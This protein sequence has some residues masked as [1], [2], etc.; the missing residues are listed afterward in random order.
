M[1]VLLLNPPHRVPAAGGY[2][3]FFVRAGSRWPYSEFKKTREPSLYRP[4]PFSLAYAAAV[5]QRAGH[6]VR[7]I[8]GVAL[9]YDGERFRGAC[10]VQQPDAVIVEIAPFSLTDDAALARMFKAA[11]PQTVV[12]AVGPFVPLLIRQDAIRNSFDY[13]INGEYEIA[14]AALLDAVMQGNEPAVRG[15]VRPAR[16]LSGGELEYTD[17]I[18]PLDIL[19]PPLREIFPC[20]EQP[21]MAV[22]WDVFCQ[23]RPAIQMHSS[24]GCPYRCYFCVWNQVFYRQRRYRTFGTSRVVDEMEEAVRRFGAREIYFDDDD[25]SIDPKR[26][27]EIAGEI[28]RRGLKVAWGCMADAIN[29]DEETV[30]LMAA[31]GCIGIKFG[32]ES[33]DSA[34]LA[35]VR[36]PVSL[37]KVRDLARWCTAYG[38]R[39]HATFSFGLLHETRDS[40]AKTLAFARTLDTDSVQF[41]IATPYPGTEFYRAVQEG[42]M[43]GSFDWMNYDGSTS[44]VVNYPGLAADEIAAFH[45]AAFRTWFRDKLTKPAWVI[46][47]ARILLRTMA[48]QRLSYSIRFI[49]KLAG[50]AWR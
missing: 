41:S 11:R 30:R 14:V 24:R 15:V 13:A 3:R 10:A 42:G 6:A 16:P 44:C 12:I 45:R 8:D 7:A 23:R 48:S 39:T 32:V 36:K 40:L 21:D 18:E 38:I 47:Q 50:K 34:V 49:G 17:P 25:F 22:Y 35:A 29:L 43:L 9:Q 37:P 2:E 28:M 26:V 19:P 4:F 33:A 20:N 5:L 31:S 27:R 1:N 46:R